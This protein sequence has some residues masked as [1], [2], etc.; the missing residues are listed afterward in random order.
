MGIALSCSWPRR[1]WV[2]EYMF[3][4]KPN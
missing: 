2:E 1:S 4:T 3:N